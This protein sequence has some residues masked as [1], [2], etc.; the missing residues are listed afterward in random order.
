MKTLVQ[1]TY[2]VHSIAV[3]WNTHNIHDNDET[4][5]F[6]HILAKHLTH[7]LSFHLPQFTEQVQTE[8]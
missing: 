6:Q 3:K 1:N 2:N 4:E 5:I 7:F 8:N